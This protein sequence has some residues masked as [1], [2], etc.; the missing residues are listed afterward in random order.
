MS[1]EIYMW[2]LERTTREV[3]PGQTAQN[4]GLFD[5][6][7]ASL[8]QRPD[9]IIVGEVRG[10]EAYKFVSKKAPTFMEEMNCEVYIPLIKNI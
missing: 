3:M 6:L 7:K 2:E 9:V 10:E 8:R 5:L 1:L 4:I